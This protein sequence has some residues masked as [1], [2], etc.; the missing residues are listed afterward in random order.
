MILTI[1]LFFI[2]LGGC[3]KKDLA[4]LPAT[5]VPGITNA[6]EAYFSPDGQSLIFNAKLEG[7]TLYQTYTSR[8]DGSELTRIND[9]GHD[10]CSFFFPD[11]S[12]ILY[13]STRDNLDLPAG[14]WSNPQDYPAGAE[15][16]TCDL[17]GSNVVRLTDNQYYEAE[18][19]L[20]PNGEWLLFGRQLDGKMDL[21]RM[22]PDGTEEFQ[23]T[24][25]ADWQEGGSFYMP[26]NETILYRAWKIE[27]EGQRGMPMTIFTIKHD[28]TG[29][30]QITDDPGT[31]W[32]PFPHPDGEHFAY[33]RV[34]PPHNFEIYIMNMVTG[35]NIRATYNDSFDGFPAF[36]PD[37]LLAFSSSR[38]VPKGER[39][40]MLYTMDVSSLIK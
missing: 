36:S 15:L 38:D 25:T 27:D 11:N 5:L 28:G 1:T 8:L 7:D 14:D 9:R 21:W 23:I 3:A 37:G 31:N 29:F 4:E 33:V 18:G 40:L 20:S 24:H 32:A 2:G 22:R 17:D 34:L 13:T 30:K 19:S 12:R 26:D 16:Y 35:K 10:A 39:R 6:A